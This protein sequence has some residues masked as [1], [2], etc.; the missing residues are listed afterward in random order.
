VH[1]KNQGQFVGALPAG[2]IEGLAQY[3]QRQL[4]AKQ[5]CA[6]AAAYS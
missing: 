5:S 3:F 6:F 2:L 1:F 4:S